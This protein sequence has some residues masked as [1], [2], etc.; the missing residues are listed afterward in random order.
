MKT[1]SDEVLKPFSEEW[2]KRGDDPATRP[3]QSSQ[4]APGSGKLLAQELV[5]VM[6]Y[7][8]LKDDPEPGPEHQAQLA[9]ALAKLKAFADQQKAP[10]T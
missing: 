5:L 10:T 1:M 2:L 7:N 4:P 3:R 8:L 6:N 9:E